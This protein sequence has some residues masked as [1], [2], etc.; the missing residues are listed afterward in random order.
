[1][2]QRSGQNLLVIINDILDFSKI[3]A[4]K[5]SVEYIRFN[6]RELLDDIE[7]VFAP[8]AEAKNICL[9]FDIANDIPIAICGDRTAAPD[10]RQPAGQRHQVHGN[11][12]GHREG[13]SVLRGC[14][15][16]G[17]ALRGARHGHRRVREAQRR[18]FESF[19]Q[20]DGSTTRKHGGTGLGLAISKQ[21]VELMGGTIGVDN[22]LT[23]GSIFWFAVNFDKRRV[24]SDDRPS[25]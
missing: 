14:A 8:Q 5:L 12:Q 2:V 17:P 3:E 11:G 19:S 16:R 6:F 20:A 25:T 13:G 18:I 4:G 22:A 15:Q 10:H 9:E 21:L 23:Q 1:M 7:H 24:D